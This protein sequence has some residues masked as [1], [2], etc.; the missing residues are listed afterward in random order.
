[1]ATSNTR[2]EVPGLDSQSMVLIHGRGTE[3][4]FRFFFFPSHLARLVSG[5]VG[6]CPRFR[7]GRSTEKQGTKSSLYS[8]CQYSDGQSYDSGSLLDFAFVGKK[9]IMSTELLWVH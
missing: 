2:Y 8:V 3:G 4:R 9:E 6:S 5:W 7:G 1:M